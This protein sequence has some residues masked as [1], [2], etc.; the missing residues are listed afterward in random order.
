MV[1]LIEKCFWGGQ[2]LT[3]F[4]FLF[5]WHFSNFFGPIVIHFAG[6]ICL[7]QE[8]PEMVVLN[9]KCIWGGQ[10]LTGFLLSN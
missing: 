4:H 2:S 7:V 8:V 6:T 3:G 10:S 1:L 5:F 9:E